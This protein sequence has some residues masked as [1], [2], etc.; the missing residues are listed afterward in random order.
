V[1]TGA[2]C[3]P[4]A[5]LIRRIIHC[6]TCGCRRRFSGFDSLWY[7]PTVTCCHCGDAWS[8]GEMLPRPFARGWRQKSAAKARANWD[9]AAGSSRQGHRAWIDA[10]LEAELLDERS[11]ETAEVAP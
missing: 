1:S 9:A 6:P 10:Q 8:S 3:A 11:V 4:D 2:V 7:G 5:Y